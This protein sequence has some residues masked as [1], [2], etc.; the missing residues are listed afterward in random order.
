MTLDDYVHKDELVSLMQDR[1]QMIEDG[2]P[3]EVVVGETHLRLKSLIGYFW[4]GERNRH[5]DK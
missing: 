2:D 1:Q 3:Y 5:T 4:K